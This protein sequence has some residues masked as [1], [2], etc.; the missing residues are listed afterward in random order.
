VK[1]RGDCVIYTPLDESDVQT[2]IGKILKS[3]FFE[4]TFKRHNPIRP[5]FYICDEFQRFIT[6]D[7]E[8]G[9]QSYLDRCRAYRAVC[10]LSTQS[11][12]SL[13]YA[14]NESG[15]GST[16]SPA[17]NVILTNTGNKLFFRNSDQNTQHIL[18]N[19]IAAPF[20]S[21]RPAL[22]DVRPVTTLVAGECYYF[23]SNGRQGR[24]QVDLN[25][26]PFLR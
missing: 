9:E 10:V 1:E 7:K 19:F 25:Q 18:R 22:T 23:T 26:D 8:S 2:M 12:S 4:F 11:I 14:L 17:L 24:G 15:K 21:G 3:K 5:F 20:I 6:S 13:E 16:V